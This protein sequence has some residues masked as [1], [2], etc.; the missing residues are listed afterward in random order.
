[1]EGNKNNPGQKN[2]DQKQQERDRKPNQNP[3][4]EDHR[5]DRQQK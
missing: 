2:Q 5:N 3:T 4:K 1:M